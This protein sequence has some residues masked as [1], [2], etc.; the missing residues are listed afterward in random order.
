MSRTPGPFH[1]PRRARPA[2]VSLLVA[3]LTMLTA[4]TTATTAAAATTGIA[5]TT[6]RPSASNTGVPTG[7]VLTLSGGLRI[8]ADNSYISGLD[9][10]GCVDVE[11]NNVV[12]VNSR[13]T[14]TSGRTV[15]KLADGKTN[16]TIRDSDLNGGGTAPK[17]L[18]GAHGVTLL[19]NDISNAKDGPRVGSGF[20]MIGN[21]VHDLNRIGDWHVDGV[22]TM[23]AQDVVI[24]GNSFEV[25]NSSTQQLMNSVFML[26]TEVGPTLKNIL[27]ED[28]YMNG[29]VCAINIR[30]DARITGGVVFRSNV[31]GPQSER[32]THTGTSRPGVTFDGS[33]TLLRTGLSVTR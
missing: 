29:G 32:C 18:Y 7:K 14:C 19:R 2:A 15:V 17:T 31:F 3:G 26:G 16:L 24:R 21:W 9:I 11:A 4:T 6:D 12:I 23:G 33:N 20:T 5:A 27:V 28:N 10:R 25:Y 22:Q 13:I 1:L 30:A 8:T